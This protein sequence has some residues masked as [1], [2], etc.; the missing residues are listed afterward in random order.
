MIVKLILS[1]IYIVKN[2]QIAA[3]WEG[4]I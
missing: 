2:K 1:K 3:N 4:S